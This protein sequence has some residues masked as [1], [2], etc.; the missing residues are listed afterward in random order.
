MAGKYSTY[1]Q[2]SLEFG[3]SLNVG[4]LVDTELVLRE[5]I[6]GSVCRTP[7]FSY[8]VVAN[9]DSVALNSGRFIFLI[10]HCKQACIHYVVD[11]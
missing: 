2:R 6:P 3:K 11:K 9:T 5:D 7:V 10:K 1:I 4:E 8:S